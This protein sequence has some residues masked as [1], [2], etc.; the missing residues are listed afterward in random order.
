[1]KKAHNY[2]IEKGISD[3]IQIIAGGTHVSRDLALETGIDDAF[4][5]GTKGLHV[6][7]SLIKNRK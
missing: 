5:S 7:T 6:A 4:G 2:A 3:E 1:M